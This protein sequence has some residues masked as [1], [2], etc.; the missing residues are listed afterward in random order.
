MSD[1]N[2]IEALMG[3]DEFYLEVAKVVSRKSKDPHT[4]V[5]SVLVDIDNR[6]VSFGYNG[7]PKGVA[8]YAYRW[9]RPLKYKYVVHSE[10]NA[11]LNAQGRTI[12]GATLYV[13]HYPP[14]EECTKLIIQSG[15]K[16][17]VCG[18][19]TLSSFT[20]DKCEE[21]LAMFEESGVLLEQW[22]PQD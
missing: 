1:S 7:F 11:I 16:R 3:W 6:P 9:E 12:D 19:G 14:C 4:K 2:Q 21:S 13:S 17:V 20:Q 10:A 18:S 8:D 22:K 5:G 15:I